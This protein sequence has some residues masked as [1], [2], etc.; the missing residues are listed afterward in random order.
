MKS[1]NAFKRYKEGSLTAAFGT[2]LL[3]C[4][5]TSIPNLLLRYYTKIDITDEEM[6]VLVQLLRLRTEEKILFPPLELLAESLTGG[7]ERVERN[8]ASLL[9]KEVL[10]VTQYYDEAQGAVIN[11]Y[12]F[13]PLF[14]R[15]SE[16]WACAKVK[17]IEK[18]HR[19]LAEKGE[20]AVDEAVFRRLVK[21]FEE[22]FGRPLSPIEAEQI[23]SWLKDHDCSL[24]LDALRR[25]VLIGKNNFKYIDSILAKWRKNNLRT[26]EA[27]A[28]YDRH[29]Q[30]KKQQKSPVQDGAKAGSRRKKE[31]VK[32]LYLS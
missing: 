15:L 6:M 18:T 8:L 9:N 14:A 23:R 19:V 31:M 24:I 28:E 4:G 26:L 29:Y 11:G 12:D 3:L 16:A 20:K 30:E 7:V 32:A 1:R 13:E 21:S 17:E 2:D 10:A 27:V 25:A 5:S 22:E